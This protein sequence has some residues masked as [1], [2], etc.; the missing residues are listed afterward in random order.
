MTANDFWKWFV[1][2]E[3]TLWSFANDPEILLDEI[4][5]ALTA[6][7]PGLSVEVSDEGDGHREL[8]ISAAGNP[9]LFEAVD[10]LVAAAPALKRWRII[11]LKPP[12][13][14]DFVIESDGITIRPEELRFDPLSNDADPTTLGIR[15]FVPSASR[16]PRLLETLQR[17]VEIGLGERLAATAIARIE[18]QEAPADTSEYLPLA[19]LPKYVDWF[20]SKVGYRH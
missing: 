18:V 9:E 13:G 5:S 3:P 8:I 14:F 6:Y 17:A 2:K 16:Q 4:G 10:R 19:D 12:R 1:S 20:Q 7:S 15:V 11:G